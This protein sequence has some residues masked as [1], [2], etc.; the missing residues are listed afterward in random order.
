[1]HETKFADLKAPRTPAYN[2]SAPDHHWLVSSQPP[3]AVLD[4][5]A[6]EHL[7]RAYLLM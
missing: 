4:Q 2:L 6:D 7:R 1:M 3:L 5:G